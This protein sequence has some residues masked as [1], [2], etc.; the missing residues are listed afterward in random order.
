DV[1]VY[2]N[3]WL[4]L[5]TVWGCAP[6][7]ILFWRY[8]RSTGAGLS[9]PGRASSLLFWFTLFALGEALMCGKIGSAPNYLLS[10]VAASCVGL[11][12]IYHFFLELAEDSS[13]PEPRRILPLLVFL[14]ACALQLGSTWHWP[15]SRIIFSET[16][17]RQDAQQVQWLANILART[18]GPILSDRAGVALIAGHPLVFQPFI[19]TQLEREGKWDPTALLQRIRSREFPL[20]LLQFSLDDPNW[21]RERFTPEMIDA[22]RESYALDRKMVRV[23]S[24]IVRYYLYKPKMPS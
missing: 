15:H 23:G 12:L 6:L 24:G 4:R 1:M 11:G 9:S 10:L 19:L 14:C 20:V 17:T 5:Y 16:P 3:Q 7:L 2:M 22:L 13:L 8:P 21:D 18:K